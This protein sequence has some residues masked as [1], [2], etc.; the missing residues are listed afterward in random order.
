MFKYGPATPVDDEKILHESSPRV[1]GM[2]TQFKLEA[3]LEA[4]SKLHL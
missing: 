2:G 1:G 4:P 3:C